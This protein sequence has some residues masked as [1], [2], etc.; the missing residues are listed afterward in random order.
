MDIRNETPFEHGLAIGMGPDRHP[1]LAVVVKATYTIPERTGDAPVPAD[2]QIEVT[3]DDEYIKG[4]VT[5]SM[6]TESDAVVFKPRAD[7]VLIGQAYAPR[8]RAVTDLEVGLRVGRRQHRM[9]VVGNRRWSF[10]TKLAVV[11]DATA[12]EPFVAM[13]LVY[14]RAFGGFDH[15]GRAWSKQNPIGRGFINQKTRESVD[16]RTLPNLEDPARPVRSWDDRPEPVGWG[17]FGRGWQ[18][19]AQLAGVRGDDLDPMFGL[20]SDFNHGFLNGAHPA[21]QVPGYLEGDEEIEMI[22]V[23]PDGHRRFQLPGWRPEISLRLRP[24]RGATEPITYPFAPVLDTLILF[25]DDGVFTLVWRASRALT[26]GVETALEQIASIH[27]TEASLT[28]T[29]PARTR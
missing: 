15:E 18:P 9:R 17:F 19:R 14:E 10:P 13:P 4:D 24:V 27:I 25:P 21:L 29:P 7:V 2:E 8:G 3:T 6:R 28:S 11:P 20:P 5:G 1:H 26:T 23:T 16:G 12:P 22:H